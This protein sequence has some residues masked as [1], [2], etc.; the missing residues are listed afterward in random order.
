MTLAAMSAANMTREA[1]E[2]LGEHEYAALARMAHAQGVETIARMIG[3][4]ST[5]DRKA[6][7]SAF[8][9][10]EVQMAQ[11]RIAALES[12]QRVQQERPAAQVK[13]P[14][15]LKVDVGKYKGTENESLVRW[16]VEIDAAIVAR[17]ITEDAMKVA[18]VMSNLAGRA[19]VWAFGR[20]LADEDCFSSYD[21]LKAELKA[22][23]EPPKSEFRARTEFLDLRQGKRDIHAYC[24]Y[25]RYLVSCVVEDPIDD[26]TQVVTFMKGLVDGPIKTHL[27]REYP[28]T[29]EDAI[30]I[31]LQEE[32][33]LHQAYVHS[34]TYRPP[35]SR[36]MNEF[37]DGPEPMDLSVAD[38]RSVPFAG[39]CDRC[40]QRGHRA[41]E[42]TAPRPVPRSRSRVDTRGQR[43]G[44]Q[45]F[46]R[47][48]Q[49][50]QG[51]NG[52]NRSRFDRQG[53]NVR[54]N[55]R[56]PQGERAKN[57]KSQ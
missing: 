52:R 36:E 30:S 18:F 43:G 9:A 41:Y 7:L 56:P 51:A 26:S 5:A 12:A 25:A 38:G 20:R 54:S 33:S 37:G 53:Q 49:R 29:L 16:L 48:G 19:K 2:D 55:A 3:P 28:S 42:C 14:T 47:G 50:T 35:R 27:F 46:G 23:F 31:A 13:R 1:L 45:P 44:R 10:H 8:M 21:E 22:T 39:V 6:T 57:A 40:Q 34:S 4:L 17:C 15:P 11:E 32:F 24:Q